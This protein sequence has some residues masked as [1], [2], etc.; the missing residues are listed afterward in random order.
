LPVAPAL[1]GEVGRFFGADLTHFVNT[2]SGAFAGTG[3]LLRDVGVTY[4]AAHL[5]LEIGSP[6]G[7]AFSVRAGLAY[8]AA[9]AHGQA[10]TTASGAQVTVRDP[11]VR[12]TSPSVKLGLHWSF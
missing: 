2:S 3:P 11:R 10:E 7:V 12:A 1:S 9:T 6:R 8:L 5:G 4:A